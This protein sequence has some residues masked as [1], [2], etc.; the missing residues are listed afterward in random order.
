[1]LG[2]YDEG[3]KAFERGGEF[4][5]PDDLSSDERL[6]WYRGYADAKYPDDKYDNKEDRKC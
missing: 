5:A 2:R 6:E 1:M 3:V 4:T